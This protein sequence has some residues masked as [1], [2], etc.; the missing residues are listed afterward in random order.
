MSALQADPR[1]LALSHGARN[2]WSRLTAGRH[3]R[4]Q[5][6]KTSI[7][8]AWRLVVIVLDK[9]EY[10]LPALGY[11]V[12][13][14]EVVAALARHLSAGALF[15][16]AE[17]VATQVTP[18]GATDPAPVGSQPGSLRG[19]L[20]VHAEGTPGDDPEVSVRD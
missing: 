19:T 8:T 10:G 13:Y 14:R 12:R 11:V 1:V 5:R 7:T 15:A 16:E 4:R 18:Q 9:A 2:C 20:L 3:G 6:L 17:G